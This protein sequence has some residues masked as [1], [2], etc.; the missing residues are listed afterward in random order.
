[1]NA[2]DS[3][4]IALFFGGVSPEHDVSILSAT[5]VAAGLVQLSERRGIDIQAVYI[6]PDGKFVFKCGAGK[7]CGMRSAECGVG[8]MAASRKDA[9]GKR[10]IEESMANA[11]RWELETPNPDRDVLPFPAAIARLVA[12]RHDVAMLILHGPGGEDGRL[13]AA[14]DLA[15]IA[16]T[17]SGAH[18]SALALHKPHCQAVLN[19]A[20]LPIAPSVAI[21]P[22][23][24]DPRRVIDRLGLPLVVKPAGGGSS[25]GVTIVR[26]AEDLAEA[27]ET[28]LAVD[29]AAL[30]EKFVAGRELTCAVLER[31]G[32]ATA[33]PITEIVPPE[34]RW[35]DYEAKYT[36]GVSREVTPADL[37]PA[38]S[39]EIQRIAVQAHL[40]LGC[41]GFSR[42]DFILGAQDRPVVLEVN[43]IPGMTATSLLPQAAAAAGIDF[44]A[45]LG[46]MID[47]ATHD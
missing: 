29:E 7:A 15:R 34:G 9:K 6:N 13:Q 20:G 30:V 22:G 31:D 21:G 12:E 24:V 44:P 35:F 40:A 33:L 14:L 19:A 2:K 26:E 4:R 25:V 23:G 8:E 10:E 45:L 39:A 11:A 18:A 32:A 27:I 28:A 38:L 16:Y 37:P 47:G 3:K 43:T 36:P 5:Q 17:G 1:M 41:R 46:L 42:A